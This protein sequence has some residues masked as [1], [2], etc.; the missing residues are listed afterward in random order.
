MCA[1][2]FDFMSYASMRLGDNITKGI[3]LEEAKTRLIDDIF[4]QAKFEE[5]LDICQGMKSCNAFNP[6]YDIIF[7]P[8]Y[9][10]Y[11]YRPSDHQNIMSLQ[12][13]IKITM[14]IVKMMIVVNTVTIVQLNLQQ[15]I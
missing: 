2:L 14:K 8:R 6:T 9:F 12:V 7:I 1:I 15:L 10:R 11:Y 5:I 13:H 4:A 3:P